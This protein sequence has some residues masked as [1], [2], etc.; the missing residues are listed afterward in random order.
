[1]AQ[2]PPDAQRALVDQVTAGDGPSDVGA[3]LRGALA[4]RAGRDGRGTPPGLDAVGAFD[5]DLDGA[6]ADD[7]APGDGDFAGS[8]DVEADHRDTWAP[9][10]TLAPSRP[11]PERS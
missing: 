9:D 11:D 8:L 7:A 2:L 3:A 1:V 5:R 10:G 4:E 6:D